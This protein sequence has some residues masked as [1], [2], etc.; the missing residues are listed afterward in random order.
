LNIENSKKDY[1][2]HYEPIKYTP[3]LAGKLELTKDNF[4][5]SF[6]QEIA[7]ESKKFKR[8]GILTKLEG[9]VGWNYRK[10][11]DR[12]YPKKQINLS[13]QKL[14]ERYAQGFT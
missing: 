4:L 13:P 8:L 11:V 1:F 3:N 6:E 5:L 14:Y 2:Y 9:K 12:Y 7:N 10:F